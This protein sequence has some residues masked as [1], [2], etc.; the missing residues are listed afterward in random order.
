MANTS[1]ERTFSLQRNWILGGFTAEQSYARALSPIQLS[2]VIDTT[3]RALHDHLP[4][5]EALDFKGRNHH[6]TLLQG[7]PGEAEGEV[8]RIGGE[9]ATGHTPTNFEWSHFEASCHSQFKEF[10]GN[11][12]IAHAVKHYHTATVPDWLP[13]R[14]LGAA[15]PI[16]PRYF[17]LGL[18]RFQ[19]R[20]TLASLGYL[21]QVTDSLL[22]DATDSTIVIKLVIERRAWKLTD[23]FAEFPVFG[24]IA[25]ALRQSLSLDMGA[26]FHEELAQA[27]GL[28]STNPFS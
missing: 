2:D 27:T 16:R 1:I 17:R 5:V 7:I 14:L 25:A 13:W 26:L 12:H 19:S 6:D 24:G 21:P 22:L 9:I 3:L 28:Q 18:E 11:H 15:A 8:F 23:P 20:F 4:S 10:Q